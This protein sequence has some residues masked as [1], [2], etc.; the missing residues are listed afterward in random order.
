ML[1]IWWDKD[2]SLYRFFI[3]FNNPNHPCKLRGTAHWQGDSFVNDYEEIEKGRTTS[4]RDSFTF[5]PTSHTLVAAMKV[6][7]GGMQT[8]VTTNATRR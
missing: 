5:T 3:C 4:W 8:V 6:K 1:V 7:G 2:T